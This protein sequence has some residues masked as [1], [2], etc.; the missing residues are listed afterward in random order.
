MASPRGSRRGGR[1]RLDTLVPATRARAGLRPAKPAPG[2]PGTTPG[3]FT[4]GTPDPG[5]GRNEARDRPQPWPGDCC[6]ERP[7][8]RPWLSTSAPPCDFYERRAGTSAVVILT[9]A[10]A[11]AANSAAFAVLKAFL[12]SDLGVPEASRLHIISQTQKGAAFLD[13]WPNYQML[14]EQVKTFESVAA[15]LQADVNWM[16]TRPARSRPPALPRASSPP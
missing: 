7:P 11:L 4:S 14:R 9:L 16:G 12:L 1:D 3:L 5:I 15:V 6:Q 13:A 10:L 8:C 2:C